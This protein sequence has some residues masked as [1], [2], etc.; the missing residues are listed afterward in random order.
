VTWLGKRAGVFTANGASFIDFRGTVQPAV[1][2]AELAN[3]NVSFEEINARHLEGRDGE[4]IIHVI[5]PRCFEAAALR[6][7]MILYPGTYSG[8]LEPW[9]HYV[10]LAR[11]HSNLDEAVAVLRDPERAG[12]IIDAAYREVALNKSYWFRSLVA[13]FDADIDEHVP[14]KLAEAGL[15]PEVQSGSNL[16]MLWMD[17][18]SRRSKAR[19]AWHHKR[20]LLKFA[21]LGAIYRPF[22]K[23][24]HLAYVFVHRLIRLL[25]PARWQADVRRGIKRLVVRGRQA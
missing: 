2:A 9:R 12:T 24:Q 19:T 4:I 21:L 14:A 6:T 13:D 20:A 17:W 1:E 3:P 8:V 15:F 11:D 5:S 23:A 25:V 10:P 18:Q 22:G 16:K 7:L